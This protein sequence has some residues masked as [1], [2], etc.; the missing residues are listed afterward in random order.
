MTVSD[1]ALQKRI[2]RKLLSEGRALK[3]A[4]TFNV[5][6]TLG[7][8]FLVDVHGGGFV[9]QSFVDIETL[10]RELNVIGPNEQVAFREA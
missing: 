3:R 4:R 1:N 10:G 7:T 6:L 5:E 9:E 2:N 8:H